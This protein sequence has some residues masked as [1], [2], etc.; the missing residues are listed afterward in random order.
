MFMITFNVVKEA[1]GWAV[2]MGQ[3]MTTPYRSRESAIREANC[4]A[5][6]ICRH[7]EYAEVVI[8]SGSEDE[9]P[10]TIRGSSSIRPNALL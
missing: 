10:R 1:N 4:L 5:E 9:P 7:G 2:R 3:R 8:E 6:S